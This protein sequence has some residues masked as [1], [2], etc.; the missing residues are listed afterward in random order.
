M[1]AHFGKRSAG[2]GKIDSSLAFAEAL[3]EEAGVAVVPGE[4]FGSAGRNHVRLSFACSQEQIEEGCRR[5]DA[6]V[7]TLQ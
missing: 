3:L 5:I 1:I 7:R 4:D 6:W 2:G